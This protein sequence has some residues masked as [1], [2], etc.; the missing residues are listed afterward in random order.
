MPLK[1]NVEFLKMLIFFSP[2]CFFY[3]LS[4]GYILWVVGFWTMPGINLF[5]IPISSSLLTPS[6][7]LCH[8]GIT[9]LF[10]VVP[11]GVMLQ[12]TIPANYPGILD[13]NEI[14]SHAWVTACRCILH[15]PV[16]YFAS[17][18][19][20]TL[21][22]GFYLW[23]SVDARFYHFFPYLDNFPPETEILVSPSDLAGTWLWLSIWEVRRV[24]GTRLTLSWGRQALSC[25]ETA[26]GEITERSPG[27]QSLVSSGKGGGAASSRRRF[28]SEPGVSRC[29]VHSPKC[30]HPRAQSH[31]SPIGV[32]TGHRIFA[33]FLHFILMEGMELL[34]FIFKLIYFNWEDNWFIVIVIFFSI[35]QHESAISIHVSPPWMLNIRSLLP[36]IQPSLPG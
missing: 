26:S 4:K 21:K 2:M 15:S 12:V 18:W 27:K 11:C 34:F 36:D 8:L 1:T 33:K 24:A 35:H 6:W 32:L 13:T 29:S 10:T 23:S 31:V 19:S 22:T 30:L 7:I 25:E 9:T 16:L 20:S 3:C 17:L 5:N 28:G 14:M